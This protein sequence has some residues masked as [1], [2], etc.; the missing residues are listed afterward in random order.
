M[1]SVDSTGLG[2][3]GGGVG[4][5]EGGVGETGRMPP[6]L[7]G[8]VMVNDPTA[9]VAAP[10]PSLRVSVAVAPD[11]AT[12]ARVSVEGAEVSVHPVVPAVYVASVSENVI[13]TWST[14]PLPSMS[15]IT[16]DTRAGLD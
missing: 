15:F 11:T 2:P 7:G 1:F 4:A 8:R 5:P 3:A 10:A 12:D 16:I 9:V 6:A 14:L 13:A